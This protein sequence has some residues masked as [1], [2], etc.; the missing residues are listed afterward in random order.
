MA[1]SASSGSSFRATVSFFQ[2]GTQLTL[3]G[4]GAT[5]STLINIATATWYTVD[6]HLDATAASCS[7]SVNGGAAQTFTCNSQTTNYIIVGN[8]STGT[9]AITYVIGNLYL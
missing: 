2:S 9:D 4:S 8:V 3:R 7:L 5:S 6:L 1:N